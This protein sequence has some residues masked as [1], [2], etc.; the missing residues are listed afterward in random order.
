MPTV[1]AKLC[2]ST[3]PLLQRDACRWWYS[4]ISAMAN[5]SHISSLIIWTQKTPGTPV[6]C[7]VQFFKGP[8]LCTWN[9]SRRMAYSTKDWRCLWSS[10][11]VV[12]RQDVWPC[13]TTDPNTVNHIKHKDDSLF[14][15]K[16]YKLHWYTKRIKFVSTVCC[17]KLLC[18]WIIAYL[19]AADSLRPGL[20][21]TKSCSNFTWQRS[22]FLEHCQQESSDRCSN[23]LDF[24]I[25]LMKIHDANILTS[26]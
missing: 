3:T 13:W 25:L 19:S 11:V 7:V 2:H 23:A 21:L 1:T 8:E 10:D 12:K 9:V 15:M 4:T 5:A 20:Y 18:E 26:G 22:I 17:I 6:Q 24:P 16:L 14:I